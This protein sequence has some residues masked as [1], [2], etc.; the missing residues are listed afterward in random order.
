MINCNPNFFYNKPELVAT[1]YA[2]DSTTYVWEL[3]VSEDSGCFGATTNSL[4]GRLEWFGVQNS[5][6][7]AQHN[8]IFEAIANRIGMTGYSSAGC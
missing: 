2:L 8:T 1:D 6:L 7:A 3:T 4:N 5:H